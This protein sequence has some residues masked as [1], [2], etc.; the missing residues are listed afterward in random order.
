M[1]FTYIHIYLPQIIDHYV[2][3]IDIC[4]NCCNV[5]TVPGILIFRLIFR[6]HA[7]FW[8]AF[9]IAVGLDLNNYLP[10]CTLEVVVTR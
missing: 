8:P 5:C 1:S 2:D 10:P 7:I 9:L 4:V 3:K 6:F